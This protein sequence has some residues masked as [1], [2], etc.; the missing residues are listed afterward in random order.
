[1]DEVIADLQVDAKRVKALLDD[2]HPD[3][4][5]WM[6]GL[7]GEIEKLNQDWGKTLAL[8]LGGTTKDVL[9]V[10]EIRKAVRRYADGIR[11]AE[12]IGADSH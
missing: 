1:M 4:A 2:P 12:D 6:E 11:R 8:E 5:T 3:R 9:L 10:E 7:A